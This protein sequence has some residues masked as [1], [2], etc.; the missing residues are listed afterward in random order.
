M[1]AYV[2]IVANKKR[3]SVVITIAKEMVSKGRLVSGLV[4]SAINHL[5]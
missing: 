4:P 1:G 2:I 3:L 5:T